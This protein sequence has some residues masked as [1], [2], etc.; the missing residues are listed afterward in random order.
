MKGLCAN[1]K[2]VLNIRI[3]L[4]FAGVWIFMFLINMNS[5]KNIIQDILN[6]MG[7]I[8]ISQTNQGMDVYGIIRWSLTISIPVILSLLFF[9]QEKK[10]SIYTVI[11]SK[12]MCIWW[13]HRVVCV[14]IIN[15][16]YCLIGIAVALIINCNHLYLEVVFACAHILLL[17]PLY[18]FF[19]SLLC[20]SVF[21]FTSSQKASI[22]AFLVVGCLSMV[23]GTSNNN[24]NQYMVGCFGMA[25][26]SDYLNAPYTFSTYSV[27]IV[28][29]IAISLLILVSGIRLKDGNLASTTI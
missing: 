19:L 24:L 17:L 13:G 9:S 11:R 14:A 27:V 5:A 29:V 15:Y 10:L 28:M 21:I 20:V 3:F 4:V 2:V 22:V 25:V 18:T 23:I 16:L 1:I 7:G 8:E 26:R 6:N 12:S